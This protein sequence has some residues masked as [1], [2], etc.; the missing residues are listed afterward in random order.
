VVAAERPLLA[1]LRAWGLF[2]GHEDVLERSLQEKCYRSDPQ[3]P[4][5]LLLL[6]VAL[7]AV[8]PAAVQRQMAAARV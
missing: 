2:R 6:V 3:L 1:V 4:P 5:S 8:P 7:C